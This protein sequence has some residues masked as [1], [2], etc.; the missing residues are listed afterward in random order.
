MAV[1]EDQMSEPKT[2]QSQAQPH[3]R[4][5]PIDPELSATVQPHVEIDVDEYYRED[6]E[7]SVIADI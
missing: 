7:I 1:W 2:E 5:C 3:V 4:F 6:G